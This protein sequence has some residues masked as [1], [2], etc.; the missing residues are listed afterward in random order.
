VIRIDRS[1]EME[2]VVIAMVVLEVSREA[3]GWDW[4]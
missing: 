3:H 2:M 4:I 1:D